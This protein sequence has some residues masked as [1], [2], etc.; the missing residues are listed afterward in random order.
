MGCTDRQNASDEKPK[1]GTLPTTAP[2]IVKVVKTKTGFQLTRNG[3]P[4][5]I[6]GG[7]GVEQFEA[8]KKAGGN[9][10]RLWSTQY[11]D[12]L[13]DKAHQNGLSVM[14][15]LWIEPERNGF[16]YYNTQAVL[17]QQAAIREQVLRYR[18]HPALLMW[19]VGNEYDLASKSGSKVF[20]AVNDIAIMIHEL[21]PNHPVTTSFSSWLFYVPYF[22]RLCPDVDVLS[23]NMFAGLHFAPD[24][25]PKSGWKKAYIVSE[26]GSQGY[27]EGP[28]TVWKAPLE[29]TSTVKAEFIRPRYQ[30]SIATDTA[31]CLGGYVFYWGTKFE[32]TPTW[33]S[34]FNQAGEKTA[35]VDLMQYLWT[36]HYPANQAPRISKIKLAGGFDV[37]NVRVKA[38]SLQ[39]ATINA[40]DAEGDSLA[41]QWQVLPDNNLLGT[42]SEKM[43]KPEAV[44]NSIA[45]ATGMQ[46]T[47]RIPARPGPYRL[48]VT[49]RDGR[50]NI[51]TANI[52]FLSLRPAAA[53]SVTVR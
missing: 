40:T 23:T 44:P 14:L 47:I 27:W 46:A 22:Q 29:Q 33:F 18:N 30:A 10:V 49:V 52:P 38:G 53:K 7:A 51:A 41:A 2:S 43:D 36:G 25:I 17:Q 9:S 35:T 45:A 13:L 11:A 3:H 19:N 42:R 48:Y 4:Y 12:V 1:P 8:L 24:S 15:G 28:Y 37:N 50:G 32:Q 20:Q 6:K 16:D 26:F 34:L 31:H 5:F 39:P 21:D